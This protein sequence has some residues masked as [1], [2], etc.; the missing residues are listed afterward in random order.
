MD[1]PNYVRRVWIDAAEYPEFYRQLQFFDPSIHHASVI[2][3]GAGG[4]GSWVTLL[5]A[6]MGLRKIT[7]YDTDKVAPHNLSTTCYEPGHVGLLKVGALQ[8]VVKNS[9]GTTIS[10]HASHYKGGKLSADILISAVDST[11][12]REVLVTAAR[13]YKI[14]FFVDGR[15]GGENIR[16]YAL[17][18]GDPK[19]YDDYIS[20]L[21]KPGFES[22]LPCTG[23]QVIDVGLTTAS[24]MVRAVRQYLGERLYNPEIIGKIGEFEW[25]VSEF[26]HVPNQRRMEKS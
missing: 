16:V 6:K 8:D 24:F 1:D 9:T 4:I 17:R 20:S 10:I 19:E 23:Q 7:V 3:V 15:I 2:V 13:T 18:P 14:P 11:K 5:L 21:P 25:I 26:S 22:E 12:A